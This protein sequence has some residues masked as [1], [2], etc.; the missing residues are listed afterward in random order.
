METPKPLP[1]RPSPNA[2]GPFPCGPARPPVRRRFEGLDSVQTS[3]Y[4]KINADVIEIQPL[5][6]P[7]RL[8]SPYSSLFQAIPAFTPQ[9]GG[10]YVGK[11]SHPRRHT[12]AIANPP[13][14]PYPFNAPQTGAKP[15][16]PK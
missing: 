6:Q 11:N 1:R 3:K 4:S 14:M 16:I 12:S 2:S 10:G 5:E 7:V 15:G 8:K 9:G 13:A